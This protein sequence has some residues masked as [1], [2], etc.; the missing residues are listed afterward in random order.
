MSCEYTILNICKLATG[1]WKLLTLIKGD[2]FNPNGW[3]LN[4]TEEYKQ[5]RDSLYAKG[6]IKQMNFYNKPTNKGLAY[7]IANKEELKKLTG[8]RM[9]DSVVMPL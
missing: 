9:L 1:Y 7:I 3:F 4:R 6:L 5:A 2:Y 8:F